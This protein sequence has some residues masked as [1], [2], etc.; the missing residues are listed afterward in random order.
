MISVKHFDGN[1]ILK[2]NSKNEWEEEASFNGCVI[3]DGDM[4]RML[5]RA[6][7]KPKDYFGGVHLSLSTIGYAESTNGYSFSQRRQLLIPEFDFEKFGLED[8]RVTKFEDVYY[9]FYTGLSQFPFNADGIK[10]AV[11]ITR[12]F[13]TIEKHPVTPFNAKAMALFPQR[14]NGKIAALLTINTDRPPAKICLALFDTISEIWSPEYWSQWYQNLDKH[15]VNL[16][17]GDKDHI[18]LGAPPILTE[19]GWLVIYSYIKNYLS[20][21]KSFGIE[22][23]F[24]SENDP[25][26]IIGRTNTPL[27]VPE[28]DYEL[29]GLV[30][31]VIFPS[32]ALLRG[33]D[34][35]I[36]YGA[37]DTT[38]AAAKLCLSDLVNETIEHQNIVP[39]T[40]S[41]SGFKLTRNDKN[42]ILVPLPYHPWE[43]QATFNAA[44]LYG[45]GTTHILYRAMGNDQTSVVG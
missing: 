1:P 45:N 25:Q 24:L 20:D 4:Y 39:K 27:L 7:G 18:E 26:T 11:A 32:G 13:K 37:A 35:I 40:Y 41:K 15:V 12:D 36:Y 34:L 44:S 8:P 28:K 17:R 6:Q 2:P 30:P 33:D 19:N 22:A 9:I 16:Q 29:E 31:N 38:V 42:P 21:Y 3:K 23:V 5:Y 43:S 10:I 14:I